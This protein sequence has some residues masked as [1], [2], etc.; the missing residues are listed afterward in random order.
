MTGPIPAA[1]DRVYA[2]GPFIADPAGGTLY[3]DGVLVPL[4]LKSFEVLISLIERRDRVV[5][6]DELIHLIWPDTFV[7]ENNLARH[8]STIRKALGDHA[9][10]SAYITTV[11]GRGYRFV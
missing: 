8:V 2:F 4:T 7:E 5:K 3:R 10:G 11:A 1:D 6:K 9:H